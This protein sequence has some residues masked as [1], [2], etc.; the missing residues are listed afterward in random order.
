[1]KAHMLTHDH[2]LANH[3][4][5]TSS[6]KGVRIGCRVRAYLNAIAQR[7]SWRTYHGGIW[8]EPHVVPQNNAVPHKA[9][10]GNAAFQ[11]YSPA[12]ADERRASQVHAVSHEQEYKT[13]LQ[14]QRPEKSA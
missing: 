10:N 13:P 12:K 9:V 6:N 8:P 1:M 2:V 4:R 5:T 14:Y 11:R 7:G 3:Q